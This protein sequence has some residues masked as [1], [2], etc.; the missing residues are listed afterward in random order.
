[1]KTKLPVIGM[2]A[3]AISSMSGNAM[4]FVLIP[5][6]VIRKT[7]SATAAGAINSASALA[8]IVAVTFAATIVDRLDRRSLSVGA[9]MLS[10]LAVAAIPVFSWFFDLSLWAIAVLVVIGALFD[11]PGR[12]AR[13]AC[14]PKIAQLSNMSLERTNAIGEIADASG[15]I[16]GLMLAGSLVVAIGI[17]ATLW[18]AVSVFVVAASSFL[19]TQPS[20]KPEKDEAAD[21][22]MF[23][24]L[25]QGWRLIRQDS[26]LWATA[27]S[28]TLFGLV[29]SPFA[30]VLTAEFERTNRPAA[31]GTLIAAFSVGSIV[32]TVGYAMIGE[33]L[34]RRPTMITSFLVASACTLF[35]SV[36]LHNFALLIAINVLTGLFIGPIGPLFAVIIQQRTTDTY[37]GRVLAIITAVEMAATPLGL[38]IGGVVIDATSPTTA[39]TVIAIG[40]FIATFV[41]AVMP[42]LRRIERHDLEAI[43]N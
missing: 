21:T 8:A 4:V 29:I 43:L 9:D 37:R 6:M 26:T 17:S 32:G 23:G 12:S 11:G 15:S 34:K 2:F 30:L 5:W 1:M 25:I 10:A 3:S 20:M 13:E 7:G 38:F 35:M 36:S 40:T 41:T 19:F 18:V 31:L 24:D 22:S 16:L 42:G 39:L 33:K 14:R 27:L 28:G